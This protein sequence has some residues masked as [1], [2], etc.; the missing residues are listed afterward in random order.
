MENY[1]GY[2]KRQLGKNRIINWVNFM[3]FIKTENELSIKY[4]LTQII[5]ILIIKII[6]IH[7]LM[8]YKKSE[9]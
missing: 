1:N 5:K 2:I 6:I 9:L 4:Y 7:H 8:K 3:H